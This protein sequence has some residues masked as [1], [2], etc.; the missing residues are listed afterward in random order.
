MLWAHNQVW[1]A[2]HWQLHVTRGELMNCRTQQP[3]AQSIW[4]K[5]IDYESDFEG[6]YTKSGVLI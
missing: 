4:E 2:K 6:N 1:G 5:N 3:N